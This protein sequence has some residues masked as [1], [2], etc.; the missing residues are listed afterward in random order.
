MATGN[1]N[2]TYVNRDFNSIRS[3]L[4][5]YSQTYFPN[6]YTDFSETSPGMMFIEQASY[7]SDV[8]A[9]YLDNQVQETYLQ[10]AQQF[11]NIYNLAYMYGYKPKVTGLATV[12]MALYQQ[13]PAKTEGG[14]TVPDYSYALLIPANSSVSSNS[15][16]NFILQDQCDFSVSNSI[17]T[18]EVT[19]ASVSS[20][21]PNYFLL[22]KTR[23][24]VSGEIRTEE[25]DFSSYSQFPT[26]SIT[27]DN[28][29]G[30][31]EVYDSE[32]NNWAEVD[33]LAQDLVFD[34]I[35]NTN[36]ND[37]NNFANSND[38]PYIL[39]TRSTNRRFVSRFTSPNILQIQFG[40]GQPNLVDEEIIPNPDNVGIGLPFEED[41]LTTAFSPT[42][43]IFTNSYGI[44][45]SNTTISVRYLVGGGTEANIP[46]NTLTRINAGDVVFATSQQADANEAQYAFNSLVVNNPSA[47]SGGQD[48]DTIE[49]VRQNALGQSNTQLRNVTADD[50]LIRALSMP[51]RF[52]VISKAITMKPNP[53][54][55]DATLCIYVL[56]KNNVGNL[57]TA[58]DTLKTNLQT[59]L[60]QYRMIGDVLDIKDAYV[61]NIQVRYEIVTLPNYNNSDIIS[62]CNLALQ[63]YFN[64]SNWQINQPII[65]KDLSVLLD[66]IEGVQTVQNLQINNIAGTN[67]GYSQYA[68]DIK[69]ATQGGIIYPSLDPSIFEVAY[70]GVDIGGKVVS[71]GAGSYVVGG[72]VSGV[73]SY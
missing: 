9:F 22:K 64:I 47:A 28:I 30:V 19:I 51:A 65:L 34:G 8:L 39:K 27:D 57:V 50:Y 48:G 71:L 42:N 61:I 60:N 33:Y 52:G 70:P 23:T 32:G 72:G 67:S 45:P 58:S 66:N 11:N 40:S 5:N 29:A 55:P 13:V 46:S 37:P 49:E 20:N 24:A 1:R 18:T 44:A 73:G 68:Y 41:K 4:I 7:V 59:Y 26:I 53:N 31:V 63:D 2:V 38:A 12:T 10:Y 54:N 25:F 17:D 14:A 35:K 56:T 62:L 6:T 69:G 43:F 3:Q 16:T 36:T 15:G 21:E